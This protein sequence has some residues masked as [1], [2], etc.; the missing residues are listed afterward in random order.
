MQRQRLVLIT[1]LCFTNFLVAQ[2]SIEKTLEKLN[3]ES[4]PYITVAEL[5]QQDSLIILDTRELEEYKV[6]HLK[7][8][9]WVGYDNF[10]S[11]QLKLQDKNQ[12][13]VVYCSIGVRSENIGE[14]LLANGYSNVQNLY[15]GI[16][17]WVEEDLPVYDSEEN[18]T[19]NVHVFSKYWGKLL[20]KGNKIIN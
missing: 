9:I 3:K 6:S 19:E 14:K 10:D 20:T 15:G 13:I 2:R 18:R 17:K 12:K 4:V 5:Q 11:Q 1:L 8:A 7:N 16:F